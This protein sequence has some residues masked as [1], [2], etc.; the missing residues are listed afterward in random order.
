MGAGQLIH[1]ALTRR[2]WYRHG[3]S[4]CVAGSCAWY[5]YKHPW[6]APSL[7]ASTSRLWLGRMALRCCLVFL[8]W[9]G[10]ICEVPGAMKGAAEWQRPATGVASAA[11]PALAQVHLSNFGCFSS[12]E[13]KSSQSRAAQESSGSF[14]LLSSCGPLA[15]P[16]PGPLPPDA[17]RFQEEPRPRVRT[18]AAVLCTRN[19]FFALL[20]QKRKIV[21]PSGATYA[22]GFAPSSNRYAPLVLQGTAPPTH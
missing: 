16:G 17:P 11:K 2:R 20:M 9:G 10:F 7:L 12:L 3:R 13:L 15:S 14:C 18:F 19:F 21:G 22:A 6:G 4:S 1:K 5:A 8:F